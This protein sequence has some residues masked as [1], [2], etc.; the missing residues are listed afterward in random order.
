MM[1]LDNVLKYG[2]NGHT[3]KGKW[4]GYQQSGIL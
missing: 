1:D 3:P 2:K 4:C